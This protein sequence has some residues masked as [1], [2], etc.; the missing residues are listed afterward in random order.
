MY[1]HNIYLTANINQCLPAVL[2]WYYRYIN[3]QIITIIL[4]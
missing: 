4:Y 1:A 2:Q 3:S